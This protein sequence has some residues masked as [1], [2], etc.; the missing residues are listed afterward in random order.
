MMNESLV[1]VARAQGE[2]DAQQ[3]VSFLE[4][5]EIAAVLRGEALRKTHGMLL[6]GLGFVEIQV[7]PEDADAARELLEAVDRGELRLGDDEAD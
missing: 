2:I 5:H 1:T 7:N 3:I 4:A 6:D